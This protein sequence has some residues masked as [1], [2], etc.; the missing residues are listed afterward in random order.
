MSQIDQLREK[1]SEATKDMKLNLSSLLRG[2][3]LSQNEAWGCALTAA[4]F[5]RQPCSF[6]PCSTTFVN[7]SLL[8]LISSEPIPQNS[9]LI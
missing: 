9:G 8:A 3:K 5:V 7:P 1:L 6:S 2:E 4:Y